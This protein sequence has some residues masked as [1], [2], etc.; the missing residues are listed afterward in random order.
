MAAQAS[1]SAQKFALS[2]IVTS[3]G[4]VFAEVVA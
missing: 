1:L 3:Y 4:R 2:A